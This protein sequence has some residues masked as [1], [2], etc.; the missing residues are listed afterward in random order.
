MTANEPIDPV[1]GQNGAD[2]MSGP[3]SG[4]RLS[5]EPL[6]AGAALAA[7]ASPGHGALVL[8]TGTVR[9]ENG[10]KQ[11][12]ELTYSA[13]EPLA[14]KRL[15]EIEA[16]AETEH[17]GVRCLLRHRVGTLA[18][19]ETSVLVVARA[20]H[21]AEAFDAARRAVEAV[22][23]EVPIFKHERYADGS[24]AYLEGCALHEDPGS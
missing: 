4:S 14:E 15:A 2:A 20:A 1:E 23:H 5:S 10:G 21:R 12:T 7:T 16:Q 19:G 13:Y 9:E 6:D 24:E 18:V 22:K 3:A 11:V 17:P 8:F